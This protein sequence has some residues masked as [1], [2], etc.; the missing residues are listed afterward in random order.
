MAM[1]KRGSHLPFP[2]PYQARFM[3]RNTVGSVICMVGL[4]DML[5]AIV[6]RL[7][8]DILLGAWPIV[9]H[10][11][12]AQTLTVVVGFFLIMLSYGL[13]RGKK[14]AWHVTV[15]LLALS[16]LLHVL[17]SGSVLA[18]LVALLLTMLLGTLA[19]FF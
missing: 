18:T 6:P 4:A 2:S 11:I 19:S 1:L 16:S 12:Q 8:W 13:A 5:S 7:N 10:R 17:R 15:V 9:P 14:H 3:I